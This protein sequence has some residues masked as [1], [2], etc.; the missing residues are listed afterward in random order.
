MLRRAIQSAAKQSFKDIKIAIYDNNSGDN[1][2]CVVNEAMNSDNRISY[3]Q[4]ER[5]IGAPQNFRKA[6][7]DVRTEFFCFFSDDDLLFPDCIDIELTGLKGN[8]ESMAWSGIVFATTEAGKIL[9]TKPHGAWR[10]GHHNRDESCLRISSDNRPE[11]TGM[12]F[13]SCIIPELLKAD[14]DFFA[15]DVHWVLTAA[16]L[17]GVGFSPLPTG[18]FVQHPQSWSA[19]AGK[20]DLQKRYNLCYNVAPELERLFAINNQLPNLTHAECD[21]RIKHHYGSRLL[22]DLGYLAAIHGDC[23]ILE[24]TI[25]ALEIQYHSKRARRA[26]SIHSKT[27]L[28]RM[29]SGKAWRKARS[30]LTATSLRNLYWR[31]RWGRVVRSLVAG[32]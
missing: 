29:L 22:W 12:L 14:V 2:G 7:L 20:D 4:N 32:H 19:M 24:K 16:K 31:L 28:I 3:V 25:S 8:P 6:M 26:L 11:T 21:R 30:L 5:N 23:S 17:G 13:R 10:A 9:S 1:T 15:S 18:V 27:K